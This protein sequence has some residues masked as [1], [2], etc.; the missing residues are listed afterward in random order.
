MPESQHATNPFRY[1]VPPGVVTPVTFQTNPDALCQIRP[2]AGPDNSPVLWVRADPQ[3][4]VRVHAAPA[5][6][7]GGALE[8]TVDAHANGPITRH[9]LH[10]RSAHE[11][12][13]DIP[14]PPVVPVSTGMRQIL[15]EA[16]LRALAPQERIQLG[17]PPPPHPDSPARLLQSWRR[18]AL[19]P[20]LTV[21]PRLLPRPD[22]RRVKPEAIE[23][24]GTS[25][26]WSGFVLPN[27]LIITGPRRG[28]VHFDHYDDVRGSWTVPFATGDPNTATYSSF[29]VGLDGW[30]TTDLVQAGTETDTIN[31]TTGFASITLISTYAWTE[32]LPPQQT[33]IEVAGFVVNPGDRI[34]VEVW[35]TG[36]GL[37]PDAAFFL[38]NESTGISHLSSTP[39]AGTRLPLKQAV[40]IMER[41]AVTAQASGIFGKHTYL[42]YLSNYG[43]AF[44]SDAFAGRSDIS[45][46]AGIV[47][48]LDSRTLDLSMKDKAGTTTL[49]TATALDSSNMRF[50]WKAFGDNV[51]PFP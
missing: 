31:T 49:S 36:D 28:G 27:D 25:V 9:Q 43:S 33:E 7:S 10:L 1:T 8:W 6:G 42:T 38:F 19:T 4:I 40:W 5:R 15:S 3:G 20:S 21:Q 47:S 35:V 12:T 46:A 50:D 16:D 29:W 26:N 2:S 23:A 32:F 39:L 51:I 45:G 17:F 41:P 24:S 22:I 14:L 13:A 37:G 34:F 11:P 18:A 30:G 44:L 48:Y